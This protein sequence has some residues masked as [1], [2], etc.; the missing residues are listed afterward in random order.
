MR[1]I[2]TAGIMLGLAFGTLLSTGCESYFFLPGTQT[3]SSSALGTAQVIFGD[4][5]TEQLIQGRTFFNGKAVT[6]LTYRAGDATRTPFGIDF[7]GD[8][9][10]DP[11]AGYALDPV[12]DAG[13]IQILLSQGST[14]EVRYIS[15]TLDGNNN[16]P[17]LLD[18][19]VGDIDGDG[20]FDIVAATS[21]GVVYMHNPGPGQTTVMRDWGAE[22]PELEFL[23]G[24][25]ELLSREEV[26]AIIEQ[27][28]PP[29]VTIDQYDV[30]V[31]QGYTNVEIADFDNDGRNDVVASRRLKIVMTPR[32]D[33]NVQ[34]LLIITGGLQMFINPGGAVDGEGWALAEVGRHE[35]FTEL[36]R[37]GAGY[38]LAYDLD[39]DG[40]LDIISAAREDD[41]VQ[42]SWFENPGST[43]IFDLS[44]WTAWRVGSLRDA[45]SIDIADVTGD[46]RPD[47]IGVG[48][49]QMQIVLYEQPAEGAQREYDWDSYPIVTFESFEPRDVK[50]IDIDG[51]GQAELVLGGTNGAV[52]YFEAPADPRETWE[53]VRILDFEPAGEVGLIGYGDLDG[54]GDFDLVA[55]LD[56][57]TEDTGDR[58]TWI[59]NDL[60]P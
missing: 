31:E 44:Q 6:T 52:R 54:D 18:V 5:F 59:R 56:D 12:P 25:T 50:V 11:V 40:D 46:G 30:T 1:S 9:K 38:I 37:E 13:V 4:P 2:R 47:I 3:D 19:A 49:A 26:E 10:I 33:S 29:G 16:W 58:I 14:G 39:Q 17:D 57:E 55:V 51:D 36:D 35:R 22:T 27:V 41:N 42:I 32:P 28:L 24:S 45:F 15:L 8:G 48:G 43:A 34:P 20:A 53:G 21:R 60:A 23:S 7:N